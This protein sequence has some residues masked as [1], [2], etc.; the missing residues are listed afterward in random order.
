MPYTGEMNR[1]VLTFGAIAIMT[2]ATT[3]AATIAAQQSPFKPPSNLRVLPKDTTLA[4]LIPLMRS[5]T[6]ALGVRCEHCH[7]FSGT[8]A[9]NLQNFDFPNDDKPAKLTARKMLTMLNAINMD[10]LKD[11]GEA[12][13]AGESKVSCYTCHRGERKPA[14]AAPA[15]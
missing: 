1:R 3:G 10:F 13:P 4:T 11:V 8:D 7:T 5:F 6:F 9:S 14:V 15:K 12:R 2:L